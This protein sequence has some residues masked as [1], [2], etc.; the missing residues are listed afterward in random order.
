MSCSMCLKKKKKTS[1]LEALN[2]FVFPVPYFKTIPSAI[3][4][5]QNVMSPF[6]DMFMDVWIDF[7]CLFVVLAYNVLYLKE[8]NDVCFL[9]LQQ[10]KEMLTMC[11][12]F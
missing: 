2:D 11:V 1:A 4:A 8:L 10:I 3:P 6:C 12:G 7:F 5:E 9:I